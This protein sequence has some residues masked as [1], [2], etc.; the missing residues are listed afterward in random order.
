[1]VFARLEIM[2]LGKVSQNT[3]GYQQGKMIEGGAT[4]PLP[5]VWVMKPPQSKE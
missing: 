2:K 5:F 3:L 1:M 4:R